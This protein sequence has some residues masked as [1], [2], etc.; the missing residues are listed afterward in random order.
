MNAESIPGG[1]GFPSVDS[2]KT[3]QQRK[4]ANAIKTWIAEFEQRKRS[5]HRSAFALIGSMER[6]RKRATRSVAV[7]K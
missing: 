1:D 2:I 7:A 5:Q 6:S 4:T 3:D